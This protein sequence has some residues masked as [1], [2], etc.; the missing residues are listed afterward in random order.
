VGGD[1]P[2]HAGVWFQGTGYAGIGDSSGTFL[3]TGILP[4]RYTVEAADE[5][6]ARFQVTQTQDAV[7]EVGRD[8]VVRADLS[9]RLTR[10]QAVAIVCHGS[11]PLGAGDLLVRVE[12]ADGGAMRAVTLDATMTGQHGDS[13]L[14]TM[15]V[16]RAG[17]FVVCGIPWDTPLHLNVPSGVSSVERE[18]VLPAGRLLDTLTLLIRNREGSG[19]AGSHQHQPERRTSGSSGG[20]RDAPRG[21]RGQ[22][23]W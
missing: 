14:P 4:G 11:P 1:L 19:I 6:L 20:C 7:V 10:A 3:F 21:A 2:G 23:P 17:S 16:N 5:M 15:P 22:R 18:T 13:T 9:L 8:S 12:W